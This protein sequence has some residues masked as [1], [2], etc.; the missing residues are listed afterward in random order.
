VSEHDANLTS[1]DPVGHAPPAGSP[2]AGVAGQL[3]GQLKRVRSGDTGLVPIVVGLLALIVYFQVRNSVFLSAG[4]LTNLSIQ[5]TVYVLL[6]MA[7][8]WLLLLGEI[9]LSIG[10]VAALGGVIG[11][12]LVDYQF[13]WPWFLALPLAVIITTMVGALNAVLVIR[14]RLPSFIVTLAGFLVWQGV[15]IYLVDHQG[16]GGAIPVQEKVLY[17]LVGGE[18]SPVATWFF[19]LACV[20][21]MGYLMVRTTLRRRAHGL[22]TVPL[23]LTVTKIVLL[24]AVGLVLILVFNSNR[25]TFIELRGMPYA[26]PIDLAI[27]AAGSFVLTKT[28]AGRYIY[29]IGGNKEAARRAGV[30][31]N[32]YRF[33]AFTCTGFVAGVAGL[34]YSSRLGGLS[35]SIDPTLTLYSIAA[36]VIGGTSLFGGRGKMIHAVIGGLIIAVIYNGMALLSMSP[37]TVYMVTGLVLIVAVTIDSVA[38]R[39]NGMSNR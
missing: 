39:G 14:L 23:F 29:A 8:I 3:L 2:P 37:P 13:H 26:I 4:N 25:S 5:A 15:V 18:L 31:V 22:Q 7:E 1:A 19:V 33:L 32:R 10:Y 20:A 30:N 9:D 27:L 38:R 36:A 11:T 21:V 34:L 16:T 6:G 28:K 17:D 12:I 24:A 35:D